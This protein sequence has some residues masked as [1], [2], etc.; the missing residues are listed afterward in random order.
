MTPGM[1]N[2]RQAVRAEL[3][4]SSGAR[5]FGSGWISGV[6]GL[7]LGLAGL[8]LVV[9]MRFPGALS[10]P[11]LRALHEFA[12]FR[13]VIHVLLVSAFGLSLVNLALRRNKL[14]GVVGI[15]CALLA[16]LLGGSRAHGLVADPTPLYLGLDF[17]V[18]NVVFT[19]FVFVPIERLC[20]RDRDQSMFRSEW[21]EDLFYYLVSSLAVQ[22]LT[23][24]SFLPAETILAA[25]SFGGLRAWVFAL[26]FVVQLPAIMFFTDVAQYW[27]HRLFHRVPLLWRFHAVHHSARSM[28]WMSGSRMHVV[29]ILVLRGVTVIP[30]IVLGFNPAAVNAYI[31]VVYLYSTFIHANIGWRLS[32]IDKWLVTPRYHHWHHGLEKAAIDVNFAIHFPLI[33]RLF[34]TYHMPGDAWPQGYG[35]GGHPVPKGYLPQFQYPF[36]RPA[37]SSDSV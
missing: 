32:L 29:E 1:R 31:L 20:P 33:D 24:L 15:S 27:L 6:L 9:S 7:V 34:G 18:L 12:R 17:F 25:V 3:E 36:T 11:E 22:V 16:S 30:M 26:P 2:L 28:D 14:L 5:R 13:L 8:A 4:A 23:V 21:R 35:I 19:G 10:M 37:E